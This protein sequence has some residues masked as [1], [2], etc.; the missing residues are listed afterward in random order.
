MKLLFAR[1]VCL[2]AVILL[3]SGLLFGAIVL[4]SSAYSNIKKS[5]YSTKSDIS[6][7]SFSFFEDEEDDDEQSIKIT[8][9]FDYNQPVF[10]NTKR[11]LKNHF[12]SSSNY[13]LHVIHKTP[14]W[15]KIRHII[16]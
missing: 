15:I 9:L 3:T 13:L 5:H 11:D 8:Y 16:I 1:L 6:F 4:K 12:N 10:L 7:D 2:N 14:I